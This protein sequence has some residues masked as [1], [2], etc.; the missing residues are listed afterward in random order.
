MIT[1]VLIIR[2]LI[3]SRSMTK[4]TGPLQRI[5]ISVAKVIVVCIF[6]SFTQSTAIPPNLKACSIVFQSDQS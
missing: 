1:L 6:T 4:V 2:H 5:R 3:E